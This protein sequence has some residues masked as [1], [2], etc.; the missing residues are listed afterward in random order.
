MTESQRLTVRAS[1][2]R[3]RLNEIAGRAPDAVTPEIRAET[4]TLTTEYQT[5]ETQRGRL[6]RG[7]SLRERGRFMNAPAPQQPA[8]PVQDTVNPGAGSGG[9]GGLRRRA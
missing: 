1:E 3:Q 9:L 7:L 8:Q 2:I 6:G 5:V 4:D